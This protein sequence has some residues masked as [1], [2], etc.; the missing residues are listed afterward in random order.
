M[1]L[2]RTLRAIGRR[3]LLVISLALVA[4]TAVLLFLAGCEKPIRL[5][6]MALQLLGIGAVVLD[7]FGALKVFDPKKLWEDVRS[8]GNEIRGRP[9][10]HDATGALVGQETRVDGGAMSG[11]SSSRSLEERV[12]LLEAQTKANQESIRALDRKLDQEVDERKRA[13]EA[14]AAAREQGLGA[15]REAVKEVSTGGAWLALLGLACLVAG[16]ILATAALEIA[17]AC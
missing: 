1:M 17:G 7:L 3:P 15:L 14:E 4:S 10:R 16:V 9:T 8:L 12:K 5:W 13:I 6:G 11:S 2:V